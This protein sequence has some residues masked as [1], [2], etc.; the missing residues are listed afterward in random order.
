MIVSLHG[1]KL[2]PAPLPVDAFCHHFTFT[3]KNCGINSAMDGIIGKAKEYAGPVVYGNY[4]FLWLY[5]VML[6]GSD[7]ADRNA[8]DAINES[9]VPVL[10]VHGTADTT[11]TMDQYSI[12]SHAEELNDGQ[13]RYFVCDEPQ[14]DGHTNLLF[15]TDGTANDELMEQ[16][17]AFYMA[18]VS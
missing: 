3:E 18:H 8:V 13:V 4:G 12:I 10:V 5:Q 1:N 15:D 16:V 7:I 14:Q 17:H 9:G 2:Y 11:V 6:F